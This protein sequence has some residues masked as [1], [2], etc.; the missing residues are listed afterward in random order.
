MRTS[1]R[2]EAGR[3]DGPRASAGRS[4][5][6]AKGRGP[7][8]ADGRRQRRRRRLP[9][10]AADLGHPQGERRRLELGE[11]ALAGIVDDQ[12]L[13]AAVVAFARRGLQAHLRR[14]AGENLVRDAL[15][16]Q[17]P[18]RPRHA[19][20]QRSP[21]TTRLAAVALRVDDHQRRPARPQAVVEGLGREG[22]Y[23]A[24]FAADP[25]PGP[26]PCPP[27]CPP[28]CPPMCAPSVWRSAPAAGHS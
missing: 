11:M 28:A 7:G 25:A 9:A 16:L 18:V 3:R 4:S 13:V 21:E 27:P 6:A 26:S 1:R 19:V 14:H 12:A 17:S 2:A 5:E 20:A 8:S 10:D 24:A 22:D 15:R 23:A